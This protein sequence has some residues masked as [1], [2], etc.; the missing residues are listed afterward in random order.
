M[1]RVVVFGLGHFGF[2]VARELNEA[3]HEVLAIDIDPKTV[4]RIK[5]HCTLAVTLDARDK[6]RLEALGIRDFD[7]AVVSF[8]ERIDA[9]ALVTLHLRDLGL[10]RIVTKAGSEDHGRLLELIGAHEIIFPERHAARHLAS[11]LSNAY[12]IDFIPL[13]G[14]HSIHEVAAPEEFVGKS[15]KELHLR[16]RFGVQVLAIRDV[17]TDEVKVNPEAAARIKESDVLVVLG[18]NE[19]LGRLRRI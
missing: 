17:L 19:D 4:E 1:A 16:S 5:D 15:L 7:V 10:R 3:G 14:S 12:M 2:H 9:S 18:S 6:E 13:G 11:R 8:G